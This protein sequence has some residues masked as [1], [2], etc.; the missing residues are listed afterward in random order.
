M[1]NLL[2]LNQDMNTHRE[3]AILASNIPNS[4]SATVII[5]GLD[6]TDSDV[7]QVSVF[8]EARA[9]R[10]PNNERQ[11]G[12]LSRSAGVWTGIFFVTLSGIGRSLCDQWASTEPIS[13]GQEILDRVRSQFPCPPTL[14][15]AEKK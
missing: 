15:Q 3:I 8:I 5:D 11:I 7:Y 10:T 6:L 13:I 9:I 14:A 4:G 2:K 12:T 1:L